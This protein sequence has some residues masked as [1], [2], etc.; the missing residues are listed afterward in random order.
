VGI[1]RHYIRGVRG[2]G[3]QVCE[4]APERI[5][6]DP[7]LPQ[8]SG[9]IAEESYDRVRYAEGLA[10]V[11]RCIGSPADPERQNELLEALLVG[12]IERFGAGKILR[13]QSIN[14]DWWRAV[15]LPPDGG[16]GAVEGTGRTRGEAL[17]I[18]LNRLLGSS[19]TPNQ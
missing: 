6:V 17:E 4:T 18:L 3:E 12:R 1:F 13:M 8:P 7:P 15:A 9:P 10:A 5:R 19:D 2:G 16:P 14:A 11:Y